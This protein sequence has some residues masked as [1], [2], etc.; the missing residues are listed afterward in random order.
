[1]ALGGGWAR[2]SYEISTAGFC[3]NFVCD[4]VEQRAR[5][6]DDED[7]TAAV[8]A[9]VGVEAAI[10][11]RW[12]FSAAFRQL[13]TSSMDMQQTD[14]TPFDVRRRWLWSVTAGFSYSLGR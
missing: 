2:S 4:P 3:R 10:S 13:I 1:V 8:Q 7:T 11:E 9:M 6:I 5:L 14:G 12:R